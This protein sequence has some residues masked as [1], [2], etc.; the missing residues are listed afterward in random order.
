MFIILVVLVVKDGLMFGR[1][2]VLLLVV[3]FYVGLVE[4]EVNR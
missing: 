3:F 4:L 2:M 1:Y